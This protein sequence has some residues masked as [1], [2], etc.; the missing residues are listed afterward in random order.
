MALFSL[1]REAKE[2]LTLISM[3]PLTCCTASTARETLAVLKFVTESRSQAGGPFSSSF[4]ARVLQFRQPNQR[5][6]GTGT[7]LAKGN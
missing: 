3:R 7:P 6:S 2:L 1:L 4:R 5:L